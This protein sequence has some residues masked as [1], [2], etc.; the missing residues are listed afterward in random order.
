MHVLIWTILGCESR[1]QPGA[2][3][4][5]V[6]STERE[7]R[8]LSTDQAQGEA[9]NSL[10]DKD[11]KDKDSKNKDS[12]NKDSKNKDSET[13]DSEDSFFKD[14]S[15]EIPS[16]NMN[17]EEIVSTESSY[18]A[19]TT[20]TVNPTNTNPQHLG[21]PSQ[22]NLGAENMGLTSNAPVVLVKLIEGSPPRGVLRLPSGEEIVVSA[23][24]IIP[25]HNLVVWAVGTKSATLVKISAQGDTSTMEPLYL[26]PLY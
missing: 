1:P 3:V 23:G 14:N 10:K 12:K 21:L 18:A 4:V 9:N 26:S 7:N 19:S 11:S 15:L 20:T 2:P 5:L 6:E 22:N 13:K 8:F 25:E 24:R 16:E 17:T